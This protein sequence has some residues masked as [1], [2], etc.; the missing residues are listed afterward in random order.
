MVGAFLR[1][2]CGFHAAQVLFSLAKDAP[3]LWCR[4]FAKFA[5]FV[6]IVTRLAAPKRWTRIFISHHQEVP[7]SEVVREQVSAFIISEKTHNCAALTVRNLPSGTPLRH[8]IRAAIWLSH[9]TI[10]LCPADTRE[11]SSVDEKNYKW[12][13][14]E[15]EYTLLL[16]KPVLF[17]VQ[18]GADRDKIIADFSDPHIGYL[19]TG[20]KLPDDKDRAKALAEQFSEHISSSF[21]VKGIN[22]SAQHLDVRLQENVS[23]FVEDLKLS[24]LEII[25][26]GYVR[27]FDPE[28]QRALILALTLMGPL[29]KKPKCWFVTQFAAK[30]KSGNE[31]N[32][33]RA[34]V[35]MWNHVRDRKLDI[36]HRGLP[37]IDSP[38]RRRY[39]ER[40]ALAIRLIRPEMSTRDRK[41]WRASWLARWNTNLGLR[42]L[43]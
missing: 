7:A 33:E 35:N 37:L 19:M 36:G 29:G 15:S 18:E 16:R 26:N 5:G 22:T 32:A 31:H 14:R 39:Y 20:S 8:I 1:F 41:H 9:G 43:C 13:A 11:I 25:L 21:D 27:Q 6:A 17:G 23:N 40:V 4:E 34:F 12:I 24:T 38:D 28:T 42:S 30:W 10:A 3:G 2:K